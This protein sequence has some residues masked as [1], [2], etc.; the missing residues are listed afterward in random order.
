MK[1]LMQVVFFL[2]IIAFSLVSGNESG[3]GD[4]P[5]TTT[6]TTTTTLKSSPVWAKIKADFARSKAES[7]TQLFMASPTNRGL[8]SSPSSPPSAF[9]RSRVELMSPL[10]FNFQASTSI[11][12]TTTTA[13]TAFSSSSVDR[14]S[15]EKTAEYRQVLAE[16]YT[17]ARKKLS[18]AKVS[19][20]TTI[21]LLESVILESP[22][23]L[24]V[25]EASKVL[26]KCYQQQ[27]QQQSESK[28]K[29]RGW[30]FRERVLNMGGTSSQ[31]R[32]LDLCSSVYPGSGTIFGPILYHTPEDDHSEKMNH[33]E[34]DYHFDHEVLA[35]NGS[36]SAGG[37]GTSRSSS[38]NIVGAKVITEGDHHPDFVHYLKVFLLIH[39]SLVMVTFFFHFYPR[40]SP[41]LGRI[42]RRR[43]LVG[44]MCDCIVF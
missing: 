37:N 36:T 35:I 31:R 21:Y 18:T 12:T 15:K 29:V 39:V 28:K 24:A 25:C 3:D 22:P 33:Q 10:P 32:L 20:N 43:R 4:H 40:D 23:E 17:L 42:W 5:L 13:T 41:L 2:T 14:C 11:S 8:L 26:Q 38:G 9:H 19:Q 1:S 6:S 16:Y 44:K 27:Q 34:E 7:L 30:E